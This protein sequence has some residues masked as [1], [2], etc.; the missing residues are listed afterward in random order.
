VVLPVVLLL[1]AL[2]A[3]APGRAQ[4]STR[5]LTEVV[6]AM[7]AAYGTGGT[8]AIVVAHQLTVDPELPVRAADARNDRLTGLSADNGTVARR[9]IPTASLVKLY[10]AEDV[11]RRARTGS[12]VLSQ[13]DRDLLARMIRSSDDPAASSVWVRFDGPR[14]VRSIAQRYGLTATAPPARPG[15]WGETMTSA[16]DLARFLTLLPLVAHPDDAA[17]LL[18]WMRSATPVAADGFDQRFGLLGSIPDTPAVKQGWMCC[19]GGVRHLHSVAVVG[20]RVVV[21]LSEVPRAV[22]FDQARA[23]LSAA[24]AEVP[25]PRGGS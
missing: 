3:A 14:I 5:P 11:L 24:G 4:A 17:Q 1:L 2:T 6:A 21:L 25:V 16:R 19:V 7:A 8:V 10:L 12:V 23:W 15:Q 18:E 22:G 13:A 20:T 9:P